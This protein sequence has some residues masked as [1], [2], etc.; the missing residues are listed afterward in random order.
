[1]HKLA[2]SKDYEGAQITEV[3]GIAEISDNL[4]RV[5]FKWRLKPTPQNPNPQSADGVLT[6]R[7]YDDGWRPEEH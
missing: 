2:Q 4:K 7:K 5:E 1:M 6:F 3:T